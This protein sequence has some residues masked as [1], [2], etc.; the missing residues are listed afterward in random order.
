[1]QLCQADSAGISV[2][3]VGAATHPKSA[4]HVALAAFSSTFRPDM[5]SRGE[6]PTEYSDHTP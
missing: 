4:F 1:M 3:V 6:V 5:E 2:L